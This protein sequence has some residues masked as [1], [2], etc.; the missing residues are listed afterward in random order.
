MSDEPALARRA[1]RPTRSRKENA[2]LSRRV[3][4][5][6]A[7]AAGG[8]ADP[9][10]QRAAARPDHGRPR[11]RAGTVARRCCSTSCPQPIV[12]RLD[13]GE[14]THR[15]PLRRRRGGLQ[16]LRRVHR[17]L[18][19]AAGRRTWCRSLNALFSAFDAACAAARRG[20]DQDDR[21]R[22]HGGRRAA[23]DDGPITSRRRRT[24]RSRC[25]PRSATPATPWQVRIGLHSGPVVAGVIG[26]SKF[27]YDLWGDAVNV[28]SRL[29]TTAPTDQIQVSRAGRGGPRR[30]VRARAARRD[31][32]QGQGLDRDVPAGRAPGSLRLR[33]SGRLLTNSKPKRPLM[34]RWPSVTDESDGEVTLTMR[35]SWAWSSTDAADAAV[36]ADRLGHASGP[37][38]PRSR[39]RACR[40]RT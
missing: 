16:R 11:G 9:R 1:D 29:E 7:H 33:P 40:T 21:R 20:E 27:V 2:R 19:A 26:T 14:Q 38:R 36:R 32:A 15:R 22:V 39:P 18:R 35:S 24:W 31:R 28:A 17:D 3:G 12:E 25:G 37:T 13:A 34:Q 10:H 8:R 5:L 4:R 6:E 30:R 23:R